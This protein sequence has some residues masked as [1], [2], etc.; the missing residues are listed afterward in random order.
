VDRKDRDG[1]TPLIYACGYPSLDAFAHAHKFEVY[2]IFQGSPECIRLLIEN[3]ADVNMQSDGLAQRFVDEKVDVIRFR[4]TTPLAVAECS[5]SD[6]KHRNRPCNDLVKL[7]RTYGA[8]NE[9]HNK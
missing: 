7:L 9:P 2:L 4:K 1:I 8:E 3:G 5:D 6:C